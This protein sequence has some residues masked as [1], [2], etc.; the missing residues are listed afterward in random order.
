MHIAISMKHMDSFG[1]VANVRYAIRD[2][3]VNL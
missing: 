2:F 1:I 3:N